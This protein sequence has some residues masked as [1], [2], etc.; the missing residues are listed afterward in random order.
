MKVYIKRVYERPELDDGVRVLV[1]RIWPRGLSKQKAAVDYWLKDP[2][3]STELRKW[4]QHDPKKFP[5]FKQKYLE[6]LEQDDTKKE[7][8]RLLESLLE[9]KERITLVYGAK[10]TVNNHAVVLQEWLIQRISGELP[11]R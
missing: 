11:G 3:P 8:I 2:A 10:D 4:F 5:I 1:D 6:E 9:E 7:Q